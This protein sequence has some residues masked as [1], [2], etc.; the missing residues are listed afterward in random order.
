M[1]V[2]IFLCYA[3]QDDALIERLKTHLMS[4]YRQ[5][6]I[7]IWYDRIISPGSDW[8][9]EIDN[10]LGSAQLILLLISPDFMASNYCYSIEMQRALMRHGQGEAR[11][12]PIILIPTHWQDAP[13]NKLQILPTGARPVTSWPK[14]D[15]A[16]YDI[17]NGIYTIVKQ[18][19]PSSDRNSASLPPPQ[20][21]SLVATSFRQRG[22]V[23]LRSISLFNVLIAVLIMAVIFSGAIVID[24]VSLLLQGKNPPA[25]VTTHPV[26]PTSEPE[27]SSTATA[28]IAYSLFARSE[29]AMQ[30]INDPLKSSMHG[31]TWSQDKG[32]VFSSQDYHAIV[33]HTGF[34]MCF[35]G[36]T[37]LTDFTFQV[38]MTII[39]GELGGIVFR[40]TP[41]QN[42]VDAYYFEISSN[43]SY[44]LF[45]VQN[46]TTTS[47]RSG[48]SPLFKNGFNQPNL[49]TVIARG[50]TIIIF[51]NKQYALTIT[52]STYKSGIFGMIAQT[53]N[54]PTEVAFS[55]A[56]VWTT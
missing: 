49:L 10:H 25:T 4:L 17:V 15:D 6:L 3:H 56:E 31:G 20:P 12:I 11:V 34:K 9:R 43:G 21:Y 54:K 23:R 5:E 26:S 48:N 32:C 7:D 40:A 19:E 50:T 14:Q 24:A 51:I 41:S 16:F 37:I 13:F 39:K 35:A 30:V 22:R 47:L 38:Q 55:N 8:Q 28:V 44:G 27:N 2:K 18:L 36:G 52:D 42:S 46:N 45:N 29:S 1:P 33:L 53:L